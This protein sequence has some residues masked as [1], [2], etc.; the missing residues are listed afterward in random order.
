MLLG[1]GKAHAHCVDAEVRRPKPAPGIEIAL[2]FGFR[3]FTNGQLRLKP[4]SSGIAPGRARIF[5]EPL[6]RRAHLAVGSA[7]GEPT[8]AKPGDALDGHFGVTADPERNP[9]LGRQRIDPGIFDGVPAPLDADYRFGPQRPQHRDLF[10]AAHSTD[11][12]VL[13]KLSILHSVPAHADA[14][15]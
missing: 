13:A 1:R 11:A 3:N 10:L 9:A 14:K 7:P 8:I 2:P 6:Q 15:P 4:N 12:V 5:S